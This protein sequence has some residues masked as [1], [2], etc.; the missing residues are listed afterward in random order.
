[1]ADLLYEL[2]KSQHVPEDLGNAALELNKAYIPTRY[3]NAHPSGSPP[4]PYT[5]DEA[6]RLVECAEK[7]IEFCKGVLSQI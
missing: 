3:P 1:V 5:K 6:A 4:R 7:I 2:S